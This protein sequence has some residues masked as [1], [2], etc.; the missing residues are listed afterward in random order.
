MPDE[1]RK[2]VPSAPLPQ[3]RTTGELAAFGDAQTGQLDIA[4]ARFKDADE[5]QSNCEMLLK[6]AAA[7]VEP[8]PWY[9]FW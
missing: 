4:N 2:G 1:W 5:I 8:R 9:R 7:R 6:E 3:R